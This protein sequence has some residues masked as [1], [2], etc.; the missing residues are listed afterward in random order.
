MLQ[1][2][3]VAVGSGGM[4]ADDR[5]RTE[6]QRLM[7]YANAAKVADA[8]GVSR[9]TAAR[10]ARGESGDP[11]AL[12]GVRRLFGLD[13][14]KEAP[15]S[16][17]SGAAAELLRLWTGANP[18]PWASALT[19]QVKAMLEENRRIITEAMNIVVDRAG[20]E[21][22]QLADDVRRLLD[23][24]GGTLPPQPRDEPTESHQESGAD[25]GVES[26]E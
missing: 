13:T 8:L 6:L 22:R 7:R 10:W 15:P 18:P 12:Q 9:A 2:R 20:D 19:D 26:A 24:A 25:A 16:N 21:T 14:Q 5:V 11:L 1:K 3:T 17:E 4:N 23:E